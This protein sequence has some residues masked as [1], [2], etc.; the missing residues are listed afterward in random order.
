[1][2]NLNIFTPFYE[3]FQYALYSDDIDLK[4]LASSN[5]KVLI[6]STPV[7]VVLN[8]LDTI[9]ASGKL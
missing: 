3:Y 5:F 1:M 4:L 9:L 6:K 7:L 8:L 2:I